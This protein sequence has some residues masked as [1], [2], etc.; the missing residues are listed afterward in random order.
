MEPK[1]EGIRTSSQTGV[2]IEF[3]FETENAELAEILMAVVRW[4][5]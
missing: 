1:D 4:R 3:D 2:N 5:E